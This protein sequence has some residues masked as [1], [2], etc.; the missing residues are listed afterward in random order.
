MVRGLVEETARV[1]DTAKSLCELSGTSAIRTRLT[2]TPR[3]RLRWESRRGGTSFDSSVPVASAQA[4]ERMGQGGRRTARGP[5]SPSDSSPVR[6][7][8]R[9]IIQIEATAM[10]KS[11]V[12]R[13]RPHARSSPAARC[14]H[15][16]PKVTKASMT[17][18]CTTMPASIRLAVS[19]FSSD[20]RG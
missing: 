11:S 6:Y 13:A 4:R 1:P 9:I 18:S 10:P 3:M 14:A 12:Q 2:S 20:H 5:K 16:T 19:R 15:T 17:T 8:P 7:A